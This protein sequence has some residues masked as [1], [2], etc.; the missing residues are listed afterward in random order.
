MKS[1]LVV[2]DELLLHLQQ[3]LKGSRKK[4]ASLNGRAI[5]RGGGIKDKITF[6]LTFFSNVP[7]F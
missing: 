5:K 6:F 7:K 4:S 1:L 3:I 2:I